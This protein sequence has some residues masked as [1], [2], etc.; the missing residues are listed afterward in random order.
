MARAATAA[1]SC[2]QNRR[3]VHPSALS[4]AS[5]SRSRLRFPSILSRHQLALA[6]GHVPCSGQPCQKHPSTNT[7]S[8]ARLNATSARRRVPGSVTSTRYLSPRARSAARK[9][10]SPAVSR[11]RVACILRRTSGDEALGLVVVFFEDLFVDVER[12][13]VT[14]CPFE[15]G[16]IALQVCMV[17]LAQELPIVQRVGW[18]TVLRR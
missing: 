9:A 10:T 2:A 6:F 13:F 1:S 8:L 7:A 12:L 18:P 11:R 14:L 3:T 5:V 15:L 16:L 4:F 17:S